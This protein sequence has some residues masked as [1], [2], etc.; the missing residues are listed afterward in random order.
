MKYGEMTFNKVE[1]EGYYRISINTPKGLISGIQLTFFDDDNITLSEKEYEIPILCRYKDGKMIEVITDR[2][3][4]HVTE[5]NS[6]SG[7]YNQTK[8]ETILQYSKPCYCSATKLSEKDALKVARLFAVRTSKYLQQYVSK[9]TTAIE[10]STMF[11]YYLKDINDSIESLD[12]NTLIAKARSKTIH[13]YE[14]GK[15]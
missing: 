13:N 2:E 8:C 12:I 9:V 1:E 10:N 6:M 3:L 7:F 15:V 5:V 4:K 11:Y 14:Y